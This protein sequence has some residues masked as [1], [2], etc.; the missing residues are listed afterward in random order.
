M[1]NHAIIMSSI[2]K[3]THRTVLKEDIQE[4]LVCHRTTSIHALVD[5][6]KNVRLTDIE[7]GQMKNVSR[8]TMTA[9]DPKNPSVIYQ[10]AAKR[11]Y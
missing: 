9:L 8:T 10:R 5:P 6:G 3:N 4:N 7:N 2:T 1:D 11:R